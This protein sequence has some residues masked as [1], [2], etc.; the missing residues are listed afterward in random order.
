MGRK[1]SEYSLGSSDTR[2][3]PAA[4]GGLDDS[5]AATLRSA[6][7]TRSSVP[8]P[9]AETLHVGPLPRHEFLLTKISLNRL[10]LSKDVA[11][12]YSQ[13]AVEEASPII[14]RLEKYRTLKGYF[15]EEQA[16][17]YIM[18]CDRR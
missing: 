11:E 12:K 18:Q 8:F 2:G 6:H 14:H 3:R 15:V 16:L 5:A 13:E 9:P 17:S 1:C 10:G 7:P 4:A